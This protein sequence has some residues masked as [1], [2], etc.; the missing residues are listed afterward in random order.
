MILSCVLGALAALVGFAPLVV[1]R[2]LVKKGNALVRKKATALGL[3]AVGFSFVLL[4]A[5]LFVCSK[6]APEQFSAFA[7]T[8]VAVFLLAGFV[9]A[10][11]ELRSTK[12]H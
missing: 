5:L 7:L 2:R 9:L 8:L 3:V 10:F 6:L 12:E 1:V 4:L 11:I